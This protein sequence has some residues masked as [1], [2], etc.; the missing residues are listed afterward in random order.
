MPVRILGI[1]ASPRLTLL[2]LLAALVVVFAGTLAQ[3][4]GEP[5][6]VHAR[7]FRSF[8][9][10][11]S[12]G[13][14]VRLPLL[15]GAYTLGAVLLANLVALQVKSFA[16]RGTR[17]GTLMIR[18]GV[19]L[20]LIGQLLA[21]QVSGTSAM[22]LTRG[23]P[24]NYAEDLLAHELVIADRQ[25]PVLTVPQSVLAQKGEVHHQQSQLTVRV[26]EFWPN[27]DL[28]A[29][30]VRGARRIS[31]THGTTRNAAHIVPKP[32]TDHTVT[33][34]APAAVIEVTT[35][36]SSLG[37]W[38]V[39]PQLRGSQ[40]FVYHNREFDIALGPRR[41]YKPFS[42]TLQDAGRDLH[43]G[44]DVVRG[45]WSRVRIQHPA[46]Q[47]DR[48]V[49]LAVNKPFR[50]LGETYY[51]SQVDTS[52]RVSTLQLVRNPSWPIPYVAFALIALG[53]C[54]QPATY[55]LRVTRRRTG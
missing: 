44:S 10:W 49:M 37:T 9:I 15:P 34:S 14:G 27:A 48:E 25:G 20:L 39:S 1:L 40:R 16:V 2:C 11:W 6:R 7:F 50:Y 42:I 52:T 43:N 19:I 3:A 35:P 4:A 32:V 8:I 54:L 46:S 13:Q 30:P 33:R 22:R 18:F 21:D 41:H 26:N 53:L 17:P 24:S 38:I 29:E 28:S 5:Y 12:P 36:S 47:D 23:E 31:V 45:L 55:L 51:Q